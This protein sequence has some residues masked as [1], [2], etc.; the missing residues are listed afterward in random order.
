M[1][2]TSGNFQLQNIEPCNCLLFSDFKMLFCALSFKIN[3]QLWER[4]VISITTLQR[5]KFRFREIKCLVQRSLV[6]TT[7]ESGLR[8]KSADLVFPSN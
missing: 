8:M 7:A 4:S 5:K 1:A 2:A 3:E 6:R